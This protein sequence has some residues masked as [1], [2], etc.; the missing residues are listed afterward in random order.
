MAEQKTIVCIE[1][2]PHIIDLIRLI[3][4]R[5]GFTLIGVTS[6][7]DGLD[8]IRRHHPDLVLLDLMMPDPDGW[9]ILHTMEMEHDLQ[10]IPV[11]VVTVRSRH[12][13]VLQ[14]RHALQVADYVTKP[15]GI[16]RL[17]DS[18]CGVLG[19]AA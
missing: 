16:Q 18:V 17:L 15:F 3:L 19:V 11:I 6:S 9:Q 4:R 12:S 5:K 8:T 14:G 13:E 7:R 1:D 2:D 10:A